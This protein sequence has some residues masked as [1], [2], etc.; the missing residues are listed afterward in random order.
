M[1]TLIYQL[2]FDDVI[3][4]YSDREQAVKALKH[5]RSMGVDV[6]LTILEI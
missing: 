3:G 4:F 2:E 1:N 6:T 5:L